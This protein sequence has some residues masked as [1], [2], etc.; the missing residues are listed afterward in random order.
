MIENFLFEINF[1]YCCND[2]K[3]VSSYYK[4]KGPESILL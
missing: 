3:N 4:T 1:F 2:I